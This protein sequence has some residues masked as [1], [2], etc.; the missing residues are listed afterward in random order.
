MQQIDLRDGA[1]QSIA[2]QELDK[3]R[4]ARRPKEMTCP[5]CD[6]VGMTKA[7]REC[8]CCTVMKWIGIFLL[9]CVCICIICC[10]TPMQRGGI[11]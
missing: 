6:H 4:N 1:D 10:Y 7:V 11:I 5:S 9:F 3:E 2:I 8:T